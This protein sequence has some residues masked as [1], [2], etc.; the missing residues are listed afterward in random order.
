MKSTLLTIDCFGFYVMDDNTYYVLKR[1]LSVQATKIKTTYF[2][3]FCQWCGKSRCRLAGYLA[4]GRDIKATK[5]RIAKL[6]ALDARL[7]APDIEFEGGKIV[8]NVKINRVQIIFDV[9]PDDDMIS[10]LKANGFHWSH[11]EDA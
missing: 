6:Q 2:T 5:E 9:R 1:Q 11:S 4:V 8:E 3:A 7:A 10:K